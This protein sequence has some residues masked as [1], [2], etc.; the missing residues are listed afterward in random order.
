[1]KRYFPLA[2]GVMVHMF[3]LKSAG[4]HYG[5]FAPDPATDAL[6]IGSNANRP[7]GYM[8]SNFRTG[9]NKSNTISKGRRP[10]S[11]SRGAQIS[12]PFRW[13]PEAG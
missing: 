5:S 4:H 6:R 12:L 9:E 2:E 10:L 3:G 7:A 1:M 13:V 8:G 11:N